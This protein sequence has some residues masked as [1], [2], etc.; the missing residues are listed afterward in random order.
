MNPTDAARLLERLLEDPEFRARFRD[1]PAATA[2]E[3]GLQSL[4][5]QLQ[6]TP[7]RPLE[8]LE[9][10]QSHSS[11][12][13]VMLAAA[14]EGLGLFQLSEHLTPQLRAET[15]QAADQPPDR[16]ETTQPPDPDNTNE[17]TTNQQTDTDADTQ[18]DDEPDENA[19]DE[20]E[21]DEQEPDE[22]EPDEQEPDE[23]E[24]DEEE[25]DEEEPDEEEPDEEEPDEEEPDDLEDPDEIDTDSDDPDA[26]SDDADSDDADAP[27]PL[28]PSGDRKPE[29]DQYGMAG[30]GGAHSPIDAAV[31]ESPK[32]TLDADGREDFAEGRM[33]PRIGTVLLELA[34]QHEITV[35][36]TTSDHPQSTIGGSPSN[37]WYGRAI[38]IATVD[39]DTVRAS[40]AVSRGLAVELTALA[41]S[42]RPD[43]VGSPWAITAAGFF[44]DTDHQDHIHIAF[45]H[46][47]DP[48]WSP[49]AATE[50]PADSEARV[51]TALRPDQI[52][53]RAR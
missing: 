44:T 18:D 26:D 5:D 38:D 31:L 33:D 10:R 41:P 24:P 13:G 46:V 36:S 45:K 21:P 29:P 32:I 12:A 20:E 30:G 1:D 43:E 34:E 25:P 35:S 53:G 27:A 2:R 51:M 28:A 15:A 37:H 8:T 3:A 22:E 16:P 50:H 9:I 23:E 11:M 42:V 52:G 7:Q 40:S 19:R 39:G 4:A 47:I 14:A 17:Q 49:A 48:E 6:A